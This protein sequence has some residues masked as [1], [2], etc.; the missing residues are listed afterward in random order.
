VASTYPPRQSQTGAPTFSAGTLFA[1]LSGGLAIVSIMGLIGRPLAG[2]SIVSPDTLLW[3]A[4]GLLALV[5]FM[6]GFVVGAWRAPAGLGA[7][8]VAGLSATLLLWL[9]RIFLLEGG[10]YNRLIFGLPGYVVVP[11]AATAGGWVAHLIEGDLPEAPQLLADAASVGLWAASLWVSFELVGRMV[12]ATGIGPAVDNPLAGEILGAMFGM[13]A[14]AWIVARYGQAHGISAKDWEYRWTP[15]T[16]GIGAAAGAV[17][18]G[19]MWATTQI[20]QAL[21]EMPADVLAVFSEG[22]RAGAWVAILLLIVNVVL[23]PICEELAWRGV[24]QAALVRAWGPLVGIGVTVVLF[25]LK[26]VL[27][28]GTLARITTLLMLGT[29]FGVVRHRWGTGG[30]TVTHVVVNLF[31]TGALLAST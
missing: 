26:H 5:A 4:F 24:V 13:A 21:W 30:S 1:G 19:L 31:S 18:I 16:I 23:V 17:A 3:I 25:A 27:M 22:L 2:L 28:D 15:T 29:V 11:V 14:A 10:P 9:M 12:G 20:D 8:I 7:S 6:S